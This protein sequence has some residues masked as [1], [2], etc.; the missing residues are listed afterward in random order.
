M[1]SHSGYM[2][3]IALVGDGAVGKTSL[4][5]RFMGRNFPDEH[6][7]TIGADFAIVEKKIDESRF[8]FQIWDLAGQPM[9]QTV[10]KQY[11]QG[12]RG[13]LAVFDL[14]N[15]D[16]FWNLG[17]WITELWE[18]NGA[19]II[20]VVLLGNKSD[21]DDHVISKKAANEF[22]TRLSEQTI[23]FGFNVPYTTTSALL[24]ENVDEAFF[25][26]GRS[27]IKGRQ[28]KNTRY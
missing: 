14:L 10:R 28:A 27:I 25:T 20:P 16:S 8:L 24:G 22:A 23:D 1:A 3:K 21:L 19:G 4:R 13:A 5:Q 7:I 11:Y 26:L 6:L 15:E 12:C 2:L 9:Y 17:N 18:N